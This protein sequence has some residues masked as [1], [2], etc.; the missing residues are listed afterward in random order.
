MSNRSVPNLEERLKHASE[1]RKLMVAKFK[2]SLVEGP[3]AIEKRQQRR[4]I[5]VARAERA[6]QREQARQRQ[7]RDLAKQAEIAAQAAADAAR[8]AADEAAREAAEQAERDTLIE[9]EQKAGATPVTRHGR[10]PRS[11]GGVATKP[12]V[13]LP[14]EA[15]TGW[16]VSSPTKC[17]YGQPRWRTLPIAARSD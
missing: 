13:R 7:E 9:A 15:V 10:Q 16:D 6:A 8:A 3:A 17:H 4:A 12:E 11:N 2:T 1:A 5:A 14:R